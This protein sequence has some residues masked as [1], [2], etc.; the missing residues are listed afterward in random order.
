MAPS[1][2]RA[3][4]DPVV[5]S[6]SPERDAPASV[7]HQPAAFEDGQGQ[8]QVRYHLHES[9]RRCFPHQKNGGL[10]LRQ[11]GPNHRRLHPE[12]ASLS[13]QSHAHR[14]ESVGGSAGQCHRHH[15]QFKAAALSHRKTYQLFGNAHTR[16]EYDDIV[17]PSENATADYYRNFPASS[18]L[19][20]TITT[21]TATKQ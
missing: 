7:R 6:C 15:A 21:T 16:R 12:K 20:A 14:F 8:G 9:Q 13:D 2:Y 1:N 5:N 3:G 19:H 11:H 18:D 10:R 17:S 4:S